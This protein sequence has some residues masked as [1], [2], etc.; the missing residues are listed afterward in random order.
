M[1]ARALFTVGVVLVGTMASFTSSARPRKI[2]CDYEKATLV[3]TPGDDVLVGSR[4]RDVIAGRG[5]NDV[6]K[7]RG[8][9][10]MLCG[11]GGNDTIR[12]GKG[13]RAP[14]SNPGSVFFGGPGDDVLRGGDFTDFFDGG[15][16]SD[17]IRGRGG[18]DYLYGFVENTD[19]GEQEDGNDRLFGGDGNDSFNAEGGWPPDYCC[20][21]DPGD[22]ELYGGD[23]ADAMASGSGSDLVDGGAGNDWVTFESPA[24]ADLS[25]GTATIGEDTDTL[26]GIE[27]LQGS[28]GDDTLIGDDGPNELVDSSSTDVIDADVLRGLGGDDTMQTYFGNDVAE[29]GDGDDYFGILC[30]VESEEDDDAFYGG[31][32]DDRL[33]GASSGSDH[34]DGGE[35][36]DVVEWRVS[37]WAVE[38]DLTAGTAEVNGFTSTLVGIENLSGSY[39]PDFLF[40]DGGPNLLWG[41]GGDDYLDGRDGLDT[42]DGGK[43]EDTCVNGES[44]R[45][46]ER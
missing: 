24:A 42:L 6:I 39:R 30:C 45:S 4:S 28:L 41:H 13:F 15:P 33:G 12:G 31:A 23:G 44:L 5:G 18:G 21:T 36:V 35:G 34:F 7:G 10:D 17:T 32:G 19:G 8:G 11:G 46:C 22:D 25:L 37:E 9:G 29:G 40:G 1:R 27:N 3:G 14:H 43:R 16:G 26:I 20:S 2:R 38:A